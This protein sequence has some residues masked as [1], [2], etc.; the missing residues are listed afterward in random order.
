M[1]RILSPRWGWM[2]CVGT[3][4][5][6]LRPWLQPIVPLGLV[7]GLGRKMKPLSKPIELSAKFE[8]MIERNLRGLGYGES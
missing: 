6:G 3:R 8:Q 7:G 2:V 1:D 4:T 5:T